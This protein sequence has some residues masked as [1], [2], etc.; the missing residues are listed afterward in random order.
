LL[1]VEPGP[2]GHSLL[3]GHTDVQE[4]SNLLIHGDDTELE[5]SLTCHSGGDAWVDGSVDLSEFS[6]DGCMHM[7]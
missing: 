6:W 1:R 5:G 3:S 7:P 2:S 4:F